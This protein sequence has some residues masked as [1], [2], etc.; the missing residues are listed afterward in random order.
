MT[1]FFQKNPTEFHRFFFIFTSEN[2]S[3]IRKGLEKR[4]LPGS[5]Y[6]RLNRKDGLFWGNGLRHLMCF[7]RQ[8]DRVVGQPLPLA[9]VGGSTAWE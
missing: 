8:W 6:S 1:E 3:S 5:G 7:S 4:S 2:D 9:I